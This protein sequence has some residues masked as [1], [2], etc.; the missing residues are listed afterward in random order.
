MLPSRFD[1]L[2]CNNI[3]LPTFLFVVCLGCLKHAAC[4]G[5]SL[6]FRTVIC[7]LTL[8]QTDKCKCFW[9]L[10][11]NWKKKKV[12]WILGPECPSFIIF[13]FNPSVCV[14]SDALAACN[15]LPQSREKIIAA[16]FKALNSTNSELQEA[17]E[18]CMRKSALLPP[19]ASFP[20]LLSLSLFRTLFL[21]PAALMSPAWKDQYRIEWNRLRGKWIWPWCIVSLRKA[22]VAFLFALGLE[23]FLL[24]WIDR[25]VV[26]TGF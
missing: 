1:I 3:I 21:C 24:L 16:L 20:F 14:C 4:I 23:F 18:A 2:E 19:Q 6:V 17:G 15:Y 5:S 8:S 9:C 13:L 26:K 25:T 7:C 22:G 11:H 10:P 12:F